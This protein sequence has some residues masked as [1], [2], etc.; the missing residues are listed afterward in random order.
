MNSIFTSTLNTRP[1]LPDSMRF[2]RS[3]AICDPTEDEI[4]WLRY[5]EVSTIIDLRSEDEVRLHPTKLSVTE[6]FRYMNMPVSGGNIVPDC[7]EAV[8][9]SYV[10]MLDGQI[11]SIIEAILSAEGNVLYFCSAGKDRAGV[12]SAVLLH[13]L[14]FDD[15]YI[16]S[17]YM[18]SAV[19]LYSML[20]E[21]SNKSGTDIE[22]IIP[23]PENIIAV[24]EE[25]KRRSVLQAASL[26]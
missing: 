26:E 2:I 3:D 5:N 9:Q 21:Y 23:H 17:D 4:G 6:G 12:V 1:I 10:E 15:N 20:N 24:I 22:I 7:V 13:R 16:I 25:L 19:E 14:G 8:P 11:D 18:Q